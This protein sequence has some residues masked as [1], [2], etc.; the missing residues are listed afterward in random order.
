MKQ[1]TSAVETDIAKTP[2]KKCAPKKAKT[3][4][5]K[6]HKNLS[7]TNQ[8]AISK[9][10]TPPRN[11]KQ[12]AADE[13]MTGRKTTFGATNSDSPATIDLSVIPATKRSHQVTTTGINQSD[14]AKMC[15][16]STAAPS[17]DDATK[18]GEVPTNTTTIDQNNMASVD[19]LNTSIA[20]RTWVVTT[21]TIHS[22]HQP[23]ATTQKSLILPLLPPGAKKQKT[24]NGDTAERKSKNMEPKQINIASFMKTRTKIGVANLSA[25]PKVTLSIRE[26]ANGLH[27]VLVEK[28]PGGEDKKREL[29]ML[30]RATIDQKTSAE[31]QFVANSGIVAI[32]NRRKSKWLNEPV[33]LPY[34]HMHVCRK[35]F[36]AKN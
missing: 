35:S 3:T 21:D 18:N 31:K 17:G 20:K 19:Q 12:H 36:E 34:C 32:C 7:L 22:Q 25:V 15:E 13:I 14:M 1:A 30:V 27:L 4:S 2:T 28:M 24:S 23:S 16:V 10:V 6:G 29:D 26:A 11:K 8:N 9:T 33:S 5:E